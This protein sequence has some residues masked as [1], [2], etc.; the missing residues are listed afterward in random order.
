MQNRFFVRTLNYVLS[1]AGIVFLVS[2]GIALNRWIIINEGR[3]ETT[4]Y[5]AVQDYTFRNWREEPDGT[6]SAEAYVFKAR[7]ECVYVQNQVVTFIGLKDTGETVETTFESL[8]DKSPGS[9]RPDGWQRLDERVKLDSPEF[10]KGTKFH[11][12]IMHQCHSGLP[13]VSFMGFHIV[14]QDDPFPYY[15]QDWFEHNQAGR[16]RDYR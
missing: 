15:V 8:G 11:G 12:T 7:A 6:W 10:S 16:P 13:T 9:N 1:A 4:F 3:F 5:P 2:F 14:G